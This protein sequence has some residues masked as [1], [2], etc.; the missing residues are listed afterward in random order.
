MR[1][2]TLRGSAR[3]ASFGV[4]ADGS[5]LTV[6]AEGDLRVWFPER[7]VPE[8]AV[9]LPVGIPDSLTLPTIVSKD[10]RRVAC[11]TR[12]AV[13]VFE[14]RGDKLPLEAANFNF[15]GPS[16][17]TISPDGA[18]LIVVTGLGPQEVHLCDVKAGITRQLAGGLDFVG[19]VAFS[20]DGRRVAAIIESE[21][22]MWDVAKATELSRWAL[23]GI[24]LDAFALDRTG[25]VVAARLYNRATRQYLEFRFLEAMTGKRKAAR[26]SADDGDWV[27]FAPD[28]KTVLIGDI[29]GVRWWDPVAGKLLRHFD[30]AVYSRGNRGFPPA[31]FTPDGKTLVATSGRALLRWDA[32]SGVPLFR[33]AHSARHF[34]P[35]VALGASRDGKWLA[36]GSNSQIR[37]WDAK[38]GKPVAAM[39][40]YHLWVDN[41]E[42]SPDGGHLY[43]P[44][45]VGGQLSRWEIATGKEVRRFTVDPKL[46]SQSMT[47]GLRLS[48]DGKVLTAVTLA[49]TNV[50]E[51]SVLTTWHATTGERQVTKALDHDQWRPTRYRVNFSVD[52]FQASTHGNVFLTADGPAGNRLPPGTLGPGFHAGAFSGDG[53]RIAYA[54]MA[55][56]DPARRM[57]GVVYDSGTGVKIC[58]LPAGSGGR[59]A[60]DTKGDI[61]AA[62]GLTDLTFWDVSSGKLIARYDSTPAADKE[63]H[64]L[65]FA[66]AIAF[67]PDGTRLIT[68]HADTTALVWTVPPRPEK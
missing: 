1:L 52:A 14:S 66:E 8:E 3:I 24:S 7:D 54:Y 29:R 60:L 28:G 50:G 65:S 22:V 46:P 49:H 20:G 15:A 34:D 43:T 42:F 47:L 25:D 6:G 18:T 51:Q 61:L 59:V 26:R 63:H 27:A 32:R 16:A 41:L 39:P 37:V 40:S 62:A 5:V 19:S 4:S 21:F 68:G 67:T 23:D 9:Q 56:N 35:V 58:D 10:A 13:I 48:E 45:P 12:D 44:A 33:D 17:L 2:G 64:V 55:R 11:R 57:R 38:S 30:G 36:T 31:Q 53:R